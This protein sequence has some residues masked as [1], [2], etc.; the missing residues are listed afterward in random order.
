MFKN[1]K[2]IT[3]N[4]RVSSLTFKKTFLV[5]SN[6]KKAVLNITSMGWYLAYVNNKLLNKDV[7][8]PGW[9]QLDKRVQF[10]KYNI[11]SLIKNNEFTFSC[12]LGE[13]WGGGDHF[14]WTNEGNFLYN[15]MA[16]IFE[17]EIEYLNGEKEIFSSNKD[18]ET[19]LNE[20]IESTIYGGEIQ[21]YFRERKYLGK[22][23]EIQINSE[24]IPQEGERIIEGERIKAKKLFKDSNGDTI[25]DFGQNFAG[26]VEVNIKSHDR[27]KLTYAVGEVLDKKGTFYN[28]NYRK[29]KSTFS[30]VLS[31]NVHIYRPKFSFLG[32]RYLKLIEFPKNIKASNFTAVLVHSELEKTF[33]FECGHK[34]LN[35]F[36]KNVYYGQLSNFIDVPTDCPQRDERLGWTADAQVFAS[37]S[38]INFKVDK[39]F[40]KYLNDMKICQFTDG[41][42]N[43][44]IPFPE[45]YNGSSKLIGSGWSD[46]CAIIPYEMYRAYGDKKEFIRNIPMIKKWVDY[47][48]T[49]CKKPN[50]PF[51][52]WNFGDWLALDKEQIGSYE[53]LTDF[54]LIS[55][56]FY[57]YDVFILIEA[58]KLN[59][60]DFSCYETLLKN[61][62]KTYQNEFIDNGHMV[63]KRILINENDKTPRSCFTQTGIVLTL[64]FDLCKKEDEKTLILDLVNLIKDCGNRISTGFLG[65]PYILHVLSKFGYDNLAY[66]LLLSEKPSTWLYSVK[67]GATT[68]WEHYDGIKEDG[69]LWSK[70]MN[71][72]NHY[73]YGS[74]FN[75]VFSNSVG[76]KIIKPGYKE[77][78]IK[79]V[80]DKRLGFIKSNFKTKYG[81]IVIN[82]HFNDNKLVNYYIKVPKK[83]K[84]NIMFGNNPVKIFTNGG[85]LKGSYKYED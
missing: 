48:Q 64:M 67:K 63:G 2:W 53:G 80:F 37:T 33:S 49:Q 16:L 57:A 50:I 38:A 43:S 17:I 72:F 46:A 10:Q 36:Y 22:A 79:P 27:E 34:L 3:Y 55:T 35:R 78:L 7:F 83:I 59:K 52:N 71:S 81:N 5:K 82:Y 65:T 47:L 14:G 68:I 84:A 26:I 41:S 31:K 85:V 19:Y 73:A 23:K 15:Q 39:F 77:I 44:V 42:I 8:S 20:V 76:L 62:K 40:K 4:S 1:A 18:V 21:D 70:D 54:N 13:G 51:L 30:F 75:W 69:S 66:N 11:T 25:I 56:A 9:T 12:D 45:V 28:E 24:I 60:Q 29:A 74:V 58:L 6:I 32:G 61:I